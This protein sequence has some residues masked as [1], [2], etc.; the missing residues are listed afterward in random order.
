MKR[1]IASIIIVTLL[2]SVFSVVYVSA[3]TNSDASLAE[4]H[5][6]NEILKG[7]YWYLP[8]SE[9]TAGIVEYIGNEDKVNIPSEI[10]GYKIIGIGHGAFTCCGTIKEVVIP[11]GVTSIGEYAFRACNNLSVVH[12]PN[13]L[14]SIGRAAFRSDS[15]TSIT[16]PD[17]VDKIERG[18]F[19][20]NKKLADV[21]IGAGIQ[22]IGKSAFNQSDI[23]TISGYVNTVAYDFAYSNGIKFKSLGNA[24]EPA[25]TEPVVINPQPT[26]NKPTTETAA[27]ATEPATT[28]P[29][30]EAAPKNTYKDFSYKVNG[31]AV[32]ITKYNGNSTSVS[33]PA[34]IDGKPVTVIGKEV[35]K[36]NK[37][38]QK[39]TIGKNVTTI[40]RDAFEKCTKLNKVAFSKSVIQINRY[41]FAECKKLTSVTLPANLTKLNEGVFNNTGLK[42]IKITKK[43]KAINPIALEIDSLKKITVAKN[44]TKFSDKAGVL[45]NKKQ[46]K[47]LIC[48]RKIAKKSLTVPGTVKTIDDF[49]FSQNKTL[50]KVTLP[51]KLKKI[52]MS[53]FANVKKLK[54]ITIPKSVTD[55]DDAAFIKP[56]KLKGYKNSVTETYAKAYGLKFIKL[57]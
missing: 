35:F 53:A 7:D 41:A 3:E 40:E 54:I 37:K 34:T 13:T 51:K 29:A 43:I 55:I 52:G 56:I 15:L 5:E 12:L 23:L 1:I 46:T 22:T 33:I 38:L 48:P 2:V 39:A 20:G 42:T 16:I 21:K 30:T 10:D 17:S 27:P 11:D 14:I 31:K 28:Q 44:N 32:T 6:A 47:L 50:T 36:G 8:V 18:A 49:A 4:S 9:T 19:A 25:T 24:P 57:G 45:Y 26:E